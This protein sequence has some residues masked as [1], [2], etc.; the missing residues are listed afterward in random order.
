MPKLRVH[1]FSVSLDGYAAG[2][3]QSLD[4]PLGLA[5]SNST[6]GWW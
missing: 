3:D 2:P 4:N 6:T 5:V 1:N